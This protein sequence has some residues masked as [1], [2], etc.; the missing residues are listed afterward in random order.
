MQYYYDKT[1]G[2]RTGTDLP[3]L[4]SMVDSFTTNHERY[5]TRY[6]DATV[7][8]NYQRAYHYDLAGRLDL[9]VRS[10]SGSSTSAV[11][12]S[13]GYDAAGRLATAS[14]WTEPCNG[15]PGGGS[16][17]IDGNQGWGYTCSGTKTTMTYQY[18]A[19]GNRT[20]TLT[21][22]GSDVAATFY[23]N[24]D[25]LQTMGSRTYQY[26]ADGNTT[27][28]SDASTGEARDYYYD[29][30][31]LLDSVVVTGGGHPGKL[32]LEYD[33]YG[34]LAWRDWSSLTSPSTR[35]L[36]L[37]DRGN[38]G[39]ELDL[40]NSGAATDYAYDGIDHPIMRVVHDA[41]GT[42]TSTTTY[43]Y[44]EIGRVIGGI[45]TSGGT[46]AAV[47]IINYDDWGKWT[48][49]ANN[50]STLRFGFKGM[51]Y[52]EDVDLYYARN[53]WYDP[54]AGRFTQEDPIGLSGGI[55]PYVFSGNDPVN[56]ID[57]NGLMSDDDPFG[58]FDDQ[59]RRGF[60]N[61]GPCSILAECGGDPLQFPGAISGDAASLFA[62]ETGA[63][64]GVTYAGGVGPITRSPGVDWADVDAVLRG[65]ILSAATDLDMTLNISSGFDPSHAPGASFSWHRLGL[66]VDIN[67]VDGVRFSAMPDADA[68]WTGLELGVAI[69]Q[70]IPQTRWR[71][72]FGPG[73]IMKFGGKPLSPADVRKLLPQHRS[74]V[75]ISITP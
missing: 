23:P 38:L 19:V 28:M 58:A 66:A 12:R 3:A 50:P 26:D 70:Y 16:G 69:L 6:T 57:P 71:E 32:S 43:L 67:E 45:T 41:S 73:F 15:F 74:H 14:G 62:D 53:R 68:H 20:H 11:A 55:N 42:V 37:Y 39:K 65:A 34:Q 47:P 8:A 40:N 1:D 13:F 60:L 31:G 25:R 29:A 52:D 46:T 49:T 9:L 35:R 5:W 61:R 59:S 24:S 48:S 44:D 30:S 27:H 75:H 33:P 54:N 4:H 63:I 72:L 7:N 2:L 64:G 22:G 56:G 21:N 10:H 36:Y 51:L 17:T 18:D